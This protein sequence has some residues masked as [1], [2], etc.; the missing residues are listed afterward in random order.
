MINECRVVSCRYLRE[1]GEYEL[2]LAIGWL[3]DYDGKVCAWREKQ[4][5]QTGPTMTS[6]RIWRGLPRQQSDGLA[7]QSNEAKLC[8][9]LYSG[10]C[11]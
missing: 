7:N 11:K 3:F 10:R 8:R 4:D 6:L 2:V 5:V 1:E 9:L